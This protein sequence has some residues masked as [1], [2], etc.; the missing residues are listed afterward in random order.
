MP[1]TGRGI[2][3][4]T[5]GALL[6]TAAAVFEFGVEQTSQPKRIDIGKRTC[7]KVFQLGSNRDNRRRLPHHGRGDDWAPRDAAKA[8]NFA[9]IYGAGVKKMAEMIG[10]PVAEVQAIVTQYD[11]KLPFV[12]ASPASARR[13][14]LA[15]AS[16]CCMTGSP[17]LEFV[18]SAVDLCQ[19]RRPVRIEEARRRIADPNHP[20]HGQRLPRERLHGVECND[21]GHS[22]RHTKLW[23]RDCWRAGIVPLLQMHDC[24]DVRF[25]RA[26]RLSWWRSSAARPCRPK[27][28]CVST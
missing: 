12:R 26:S 25:A 16:P 14:R 21:P 9:K 11:R 6:R 19:G 28:L 13:R 23:M 3:F 22:A 27:C 5:T 10:K 7:C 2:A 18:R 24:L 17:A 1:A 8:T 15:S 20:W 4:A